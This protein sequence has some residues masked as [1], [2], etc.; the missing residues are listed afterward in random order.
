MLFGED[1]EEGR[2]VLAAEAALSGP[3]PD[4]V[5][6]RWIW[7]P[8]IGGAGSYMTVARRKRG[9]SESRE[10]E[11]MGVDVNRT[12]NSATTCG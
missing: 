8:N 3:S 5:R 11:G 4:Q 7:F 10:G 2:T 12:S 9:Q 6:S 1:R